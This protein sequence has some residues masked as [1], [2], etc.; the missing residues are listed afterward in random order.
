METSFKSLGDYWVAWY[1]NSF[2]DRD[3][4]FFPQA[5]LDADIAAMHKSGEFPE[6]WFGHKSWAK[7][8]R[9]VTA[10]RIGRFAVA[11]GRWYDTPVA[12]VLKA[13]IQAHPKWEMSF[14][15]RYA[16]KRQGVFSGVRTFEISVLPPGMAANP[17]TAFSKGQ[18]AMNV[19]NPQ[20]LAVIE[21]SLQE[22]G[23]DPS[24]VIADL[25]AQATQKAK[26]L[27][28]AQVASKAMGG[29]DKAMPGVM[30][31]GVMLDEKMNELKGMMQS[32][33]DEKMNDMLEK[34]TASVLDRV[35]DAKPPRREEEDE[36]EVEVELPEAKAAANANIYD[37]L[38]LLATELQ[39]MQA[40]LSGV[41]A[42]QDR[43]SQLQTAPPNV[44]A[45]MN[46]LPDP[47]QT[48]GAIM[49]Y[50]GQNGNPPR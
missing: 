19:H 24:T 6:L 2:Q 47:A 42:N 18:K 32:Y 23:F 3:G 39:K 5:V 41:K 33:L 10:F 37:G 22:M 11:I 13:K 50:V 9:A 25:Q 12:K 26:V 17:Y 45:M 16:D 30:L 21:K 40:Q 48:S 8:G 49:R 20:A 7:L 46:D 31:D 1:A 15:F 36:A 4:E 43:V 38:A 29:P 44:L 28:A 35:M 34:V 14:G 27:E